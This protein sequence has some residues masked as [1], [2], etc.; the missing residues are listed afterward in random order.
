M[1]TNLLVGPSFLSYVVII[2]IQDGR[3]G[4]RSNRKG[5][6]SQKRGT[7]NLHIKEQNA[8]IDISTVYTDGGLGRGR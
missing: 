7:E 8:E 2:K 1:D 3:D 4:E 5:G 6:V